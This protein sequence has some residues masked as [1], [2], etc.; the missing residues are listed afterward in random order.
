[1][2]RL[3]PRNKALISVIIATRLL[4]TA[5]LVLFLAPM[6]NLDSSDPPTKALYVWSQGYNMLLFESERDRFFDIAEREGINTVYFSIDVDSVNF[7]RRVWRGVAN[8]YLGFIRAAQARDIEIHALIS[9]PASTVLPNPV[10]HQAYIEAILKYNVE[11]AGYE[12]AGINW[13]VEPLTN[14]ASQM[15]DYMQTM[16]AISYSGQTIVSQGLILSAYLDAPYYL[17]SGARELYREFD[18]IAL[19]TYED[20]VGGVIARAR[21]GPR[22]CEEEGIQFLIGVETDELPTSR[23][24]NTL[25]E[26]GRDTYHILEAG[27]DTY[28]ANSYPQYAGQYLHHFGK[29]VSWWYMI[30]ATAWPQ[31]E[32]QAGQQVPVTVTLRRSDIYPSGPIGVLLR[33]RGDTGNTWEVSRIVVLSGRETRAVTLEWTVPDSAPAGSYDIEVS[34]WD[35]DLGGNNSTLYYTDFNGDKAA[36]EAIDMAELTAMSGLSGMRDPF[37]PLDN[38]GWNE[39]S[40]R[41]V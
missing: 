24:W 17:G 28:F 25:Y 18:V 22:I 21:D 31:G 4:I 19:N 36:M 38:T 9:G 10:A 12:F 37:V 23:Y 26:E 34:T 16:K 13:D 41:V 27:I 3:T 35:I 29:A 30:S 32:Y 39:G 5:G 1:M 8:G 20:S 15:V 33:I 40:F 7:F 11:N 14:I 2:K 6:L